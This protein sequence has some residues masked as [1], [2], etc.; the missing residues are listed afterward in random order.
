MSL[1]STLT[2]VAE[3]TIFKTF[4]TQGLKHSDPV[5]LMVAG[6]KT[7]QG[8]PGNWIQVYTDGSAFKGTMNDGYG[9]RMEYAETT[10]EGIVNSC[11][12]FCSN[13]E[14]EALAIEAAIQ[15]QF[16][17]SRERKQ[18]V[19]IFFRLHVCTTNT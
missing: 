18:N 3:I 4:C 19:G 9:M 17:I 2:Y 7:V 16:T 5:E 13:Y 6:L 8:Y 15:Q 12:V 10:S 1:I 11:G 14:A